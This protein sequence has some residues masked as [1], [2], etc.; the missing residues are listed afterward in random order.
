MS[1]TGSNQGSDEWGNCSNVSKTI[2]KQII[3]GS[4]GYSANGPMGVSSPMSKIIP[5]QGRDCSNVSKTIEKQG[6]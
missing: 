5:K 6:I 4:L 3:D 2:A 1:K